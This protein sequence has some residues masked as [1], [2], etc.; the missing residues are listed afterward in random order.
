M[1]PTQLLIDKLSKI[2]TDPKT[3]SLVK[4]VVTE[5]IQD[6]KTWAMDLAKS[7]A[8]LEIKSDSV[9]IVVDDDIQISG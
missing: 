4:I 8:P 7:N 3:F 2:V 6:I 9:E 5:S 1:D